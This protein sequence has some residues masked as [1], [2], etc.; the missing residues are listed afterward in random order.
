MSPAQGNSSLASKLENP[1]FPQIKIFPQ[2]VNSGRKPVH[3][4]DFN[5]DMLQK[6]TH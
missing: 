4:N 3:R 2:M 6:M 5:L 1:I